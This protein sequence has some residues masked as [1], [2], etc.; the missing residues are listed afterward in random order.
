MRS[1]ILKSILALSLT[2]ASINAMEGLKDDTYFKGLQANIYNGQKLAQWNKS[3]KYD[4]WKAYG[5]IRPDFIPQMQWNTAMPSLYTEF[6][7]QLA[8]ESRNSNK[9]N[10]VEEGRLQQNQQGLAQSKETLLSKPIEGQN[11]G[12]H[13]AQYEESVKRLAEQHKVDQTKNI[14]NTGLI[15]S[16]KAYFEGLQERLRRLQDAMTRKPENN[17]NNTK[18]VQEQ[19]QAVQ[20]QE[21]IQAMQDLQQEFQNLQVGDSQEDQVLKLKIAELQGRL[22][23]QR[24]LWDDAENFHRA[25]AESRLRAQEKT[26]EAERNH[27]WLRSMKADI[28]GSEKLAKEVE[29]SAGLIKMQEE[30]MLGLE[31]TPAKAQRVNALVPKLIDLYG[32]GN[33]ETAYNALRNILELPDPIEMTDL[34]KVAELK[35]D[36]DQKDNNLAMLKIILSYMVEEKHKDAVH[37]HAQTAE[38]QKDAT[39]KEAEAAKNRTDADGQLAQAIFAEDEANK[40][41]KQ[42]KDGFAQIQEE[43]NKLMGIGAPVEPTMYQ[44]DEHGNMFYI[45]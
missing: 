27:Q 28:D 17:T 41:L 8:N 34:I 21:Q 23:A 12:L 24:Q 32:K 7:K 5:Q 26:N 19:M 36:E 30:G 29:E 20:A 10:V 38:M 40:K 13:I 2:V 4:L 35:G 31:G 43:L 11:T 15:E 16:R 14:V 44:T 42:M 25:A 45:N 22:N 9:L 3:D 37:R 1:N 18:Q 33:L 39:A 6:Q